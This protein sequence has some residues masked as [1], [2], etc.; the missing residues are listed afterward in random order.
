VEAAIAITVSGTKFIARMG[1]GAGTC[2][3]RVAGRLNFETQHIR[4][5]FCSCKIVCQP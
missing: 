1:V 3:V 2:G 4:G 5:I